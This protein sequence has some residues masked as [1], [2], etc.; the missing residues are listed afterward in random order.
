MIPAADIETG[1]YAKRKGDRK[2]S[3]LRTRLAGD[4]Y[5]GWWGAEEEGQTRPIA[6]HQITRVGA[7]VLSSRG[8]SVIREVARVDHEAKEPSTTGA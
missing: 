7:R 5:D 1:M 6:R 3:F 8:H 2:W 4:R